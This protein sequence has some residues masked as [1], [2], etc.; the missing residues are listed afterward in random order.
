MSSFPQIRINRLLF[1]V[2]VHNL[3]QIL[4]QLDKILLH[5]EL[6]GLRKVW[7]DDVVSALL[8]IE[9]EGLARVFLLVAVV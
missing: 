7:L 2:S 6:V 1:F 9:Q 5:F 8:G 4:L 3:N